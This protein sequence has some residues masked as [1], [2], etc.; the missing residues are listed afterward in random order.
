M[1]LN[2]ENSLINQK[3]I[4]SKKYQKKLNE[5]SS[6]LHNPDHSAGTTWVDWPVS[7]DKKEF[8]TVQK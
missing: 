3:K 5:I 2:L 8:A 6:T 1:I 7:Y 4:Y